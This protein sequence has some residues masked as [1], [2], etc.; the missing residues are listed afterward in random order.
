MSRLPTEALVWKRPPVFVKVIWVRFI[1]AIFLIQMAIRF[2]AFIALTEPERSGSQTAQLD[3]IGKE[4]VTL[5]CVHE[6]I[7]AVS[8]R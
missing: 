1:Y 5:V 7:L 8:G 3:D 2:V 6:P 4:S